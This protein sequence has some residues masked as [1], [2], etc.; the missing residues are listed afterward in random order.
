MCVFARQN[1]ATDP[2]FSQMN[3][4][5]CRNLLIY[6]Q[7]A[8]QGKI[9][10]ILHYALKPSGFL[11]LG[12]SES[13]FAFPNLFSTVDKKHKIYAK[14]AIA[15]RL[16]CDFVQTYHF[17]ANIV[18]GNS[19]PET[20]LGTAEGEWDV[21][22]EA[23]REVLRNHAPVGVVINSS[24]DVIQ[25]RGRTTPYLEQASGKPSLNL[26]KMARN[27]LAVELRA[28]IT[29]AMRKGVRIGKD[30]VS[31]DDK[32]HKR[33][34]NISVSPLEDNGRRSQFLLVLFDDVTPKGTIDAVGLARKSA[35]TGSRN[36]GASLRTMQELAKTRD[37]LHSAIESEEALKEKFQSANE[38][39]LSANEELQN[40]NEELETSKEELQSTNE[41]L[42]TLNAELRH[43]NN[44][45]HGLHDDISNVLNSTRIPLV[46]LNRH[47]QIRRF[48]PTA[49][50]MLKIVSTDV[51]RSIADLR[52]NIEA[53]T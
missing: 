5:A 3:L 8:L 27:G 30:G 7:P 20:M 21:Q 46:M 4:V 28:L 23:D 38:E 36:G 2:P 16:H 40:T 34:L 11:V 41:E 22:A 29:A 24:M 26:L 47:L 9:I 1:L 39:I 13:V 19:K 48:T 15:S 25:F 43:K 53:R 31:F 12:A 49:D 51:G 37:A 45:L 10:S 35:K 18:G 17:A 42:N 33:I 14:K 44:E 50:K 32:N 6:I 52:F